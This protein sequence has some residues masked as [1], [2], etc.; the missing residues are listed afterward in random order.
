MRVNNYSGY[1]PV[2]LCTLIHFL[3]CYNF[4]KFAV[5]VS[6]LFIEK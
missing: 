5:F 4:N 1:N 6:V 2:N 3:G